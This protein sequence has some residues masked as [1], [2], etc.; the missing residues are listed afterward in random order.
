MIEPLGSDTL[1]FFTLD[2]NETVARLSPR[3]LGARPPER[4]RLKL[5]LARMHLFSAEDGRALRAAPAPAPQ[6]LAAARAR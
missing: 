6:P 5:D 1:V 2:G 3:E 4:L